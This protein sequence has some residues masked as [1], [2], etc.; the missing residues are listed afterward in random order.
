MDQVALPYITG[1]LFM[2]LCERQMCSLPLSAIAD[3]QSRIVTAVTSVTPEMFDKA[4]CRKC[5]IVSN[6]KTVFF[7]TRGVNVT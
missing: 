1:L 7:R 4:L 2:G 3:H 6:P 5:G